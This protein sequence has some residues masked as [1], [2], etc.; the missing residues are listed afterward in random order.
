MLGSSVVDYAITDMDPENINAFIVMPQTPLSDHSQ[1]PLYLNKTEP[2]QKDHQP[3]ASL[4]NLEP[5][6][7]WGQNSTAEYQAA[8]DSAEM[9][10]MLDRFQQTQYPSS[11]ESLNL[12]TK[13]LNSIFVQLA[14]KSNLKPRLKNKNQAGE[15]WF[16]NDCVMA[17]KQLRQLSKPNDIEGHLRYHQ[18]LK[19]YKQ[20]LR[21]KKKQ[22]MSKEID[23][24]ENAINQNTFWELW[25]D[26]HSSNTKEKLTIQN[27]NIWKKHF[28]ELYQK[29]ERE[30]FNSNQ[31]SI[32]KKL[33]RL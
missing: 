20:L 12:A 33:K 18:A 1:V 27:G 10:A 24:I 31:T 32:Y 30:T 15:K 28:K 6:Y 17:R 11:N 26:L 5:A 2:A 3:T 16:D 13:H 19:M 22:Y 4:F 14:I 29:P 7:R 23:K 8:L 9:E 21:K 25:K